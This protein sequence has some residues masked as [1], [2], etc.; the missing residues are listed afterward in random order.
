M[1]K[2][3][4]FDLAKLYRGVPLGAKYISTIMTS[5]ILVA[6]HA[7]SCTPDTSILD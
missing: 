4:A 6:P 3:D 7:L 1:T 5:N 2:G